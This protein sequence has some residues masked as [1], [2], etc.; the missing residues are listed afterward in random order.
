MLKEFLNGLISKLNNLLENKEENKTKVPRTVRSLRIYDEIYGVDDTF[1]AKK[2]T[3][4]STQAEQKTTTQSNNNNKDKS[5]DVVVPEKVY[6][7]DFF[8]DYPIKWVAETRK[9]YYASKGIEK[10]IEW[11]QKP[12]PKQR[13]DV[14]KYSKLYEGKSKPDEEQIRLFPELTEKTKILREYAKELTRGLKFEYKHIKAYDH[15]ELMRFKKELIYEKYNAIQYVIEQGVNIFL[16]RRP[17]V[18]PIEILEGDFSIIENLSYA[19]DAYIHRVNKFLKE[20]F[21]NEPLD[22]YIQESINKFESIKEK[23]PDKESFEKM[24]YQ[25]LA[26]ILIEIKAEIDTIRYDYRIKKPSFKEI[27]NYMEELSK[28]ILVKQIDYSYQSRINYIKEIEKEIEK[29][30]EEFGYEKDEKRVFLLSTFIKNDKDAAAEVIMTATKIK[31]RMMEFVDAIKKGD[32]PEN[33]LKENYTLSMLAGFITGYMNPTTRDINYRERYSYDRPIVG[34]WK[35]EIPDIFDPGD[36]LRKTLG[37]KDKYDLMKFVYNNPEKV[38]ELIQQL[39]LESKEKID[40]KIKRYKEEMAGFEG[41]ILQYIKEVN[42]IEEEYEKIIKSI[43]EKYQVEI[44]KLKEEEEKIKNIEVSSEKIK[45]LTEEGRKIREKLAELSIQMSL[46]TISEEDRKEIS[47]RIR[48]LSGR[49]NEISD[50]LDLTM[51]LE[52]IRQKLLEKMG[53]N[54]KIELKQIKEEKIKE[55]NQKI[56]N[57]EGRKKEEIREKEKMYYNDKDR[58][59][60][61]LLKMLDRVSYFANIPVLEDIKNTDFT[62][63]NEKYLSHFVNLLRRLNDAEK[64]QFEIETKRLTKLSQLMGYSLDALMKY[65]YFTPEEAEELVATFA[66]AIEKM[67]LSEPELQYK[68]DKIFTEDIY[69]IVQ[70]PPYGDT[71]NEDYLYGTVVFFPREI[72]ELF[73]KF[74]FELY[75]EIFGFLDRDY[76][77]KKLSK[78]KEQTLREFGFDSDIDIMNFSHPDSPKLQYIIRYLFAAGILVNRLAERLIIF[79]E[80]ADKKEETLTMEK[81]RRDHNFY[82]IK[83][84]MEEGQK[85]DDILQNKHITKEFIEEMRKKAVE[86]VIKG[87]TEFAEESGEKKFQEFLRTKDINTLPEYMKKG[88]EKMIEDEFE[89]YIKNATIIYDYTAFQHYDAEMKKEWEVD[90]LPKEKED[91]LYRKRDLFLMAYK[92]GIPF[93]FIPEFLKLNNKELYQFF[94]DHGIPVKLKEEKENI[95]TTEENERR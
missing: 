74:R 39:T 13:E 2:N 49:L 47:K 87:V 51:Q 92:A 24:S 56:K 64:K 28:I 48:E 80:L 52:E 61:P 23:Y 11:Y 17:T 46:E 90:T 6:K 86:T 62:K 16:S 9:K 7:I 25:E 54:V 88:V 66:I 31:T 70:V 14:G 15:K 53:D 41:K 42:K 3:E 77:D 76:F 35:E 71:D 30:K 78:Y 82:G 69:D 50:K 63:Y 81:S 93:A 84:K 18:N 5:S 94:K 73:N 57:L 91:T 65:V 22:D 29:M 68:I 10:L 37:L 4:K 59:E 27:D 75:P 83:V 67:F 45:E 33:F 43:E 85:L 58:F 34:H 89:K 19:Y 40:E 1:S 8:D 32:I 95:N 44:D 60:I 12:F 36:Y 55:I 26:K 21:P 20:L 38:Y 72:E 79:T